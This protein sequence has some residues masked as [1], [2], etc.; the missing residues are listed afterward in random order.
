MLALFA[1]SSPP[2]TTKNNMR[3]PQRDGTTGYNRPSQKLN[4]LMALHGRSSRTPSNFLTDPHGVRGPQFE[5]GVVTGRRPAV[6]GLSNTST[7][8][9]CT[10]TN[11]W[12]GPAFTTSARKTV[13]TLVTG[14]ARLYRQLGPRPGVRVY[15]RR[16]FRGRAHSPLCTHSTDTTCS[17]L[18]R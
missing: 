13:A 17:A 5:K 16:L 8:K 14:R 3:L 1:L 15:R 9:H 12:A 10:T 18:T 4:N 6:R 11:T 2:G 7:L